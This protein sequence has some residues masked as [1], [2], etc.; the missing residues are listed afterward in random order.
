MYTV[1]GTGEHGVGGDGGAARR[2]QVG[3]A[4]DPSSYALTLGFAAL[5]VDYQGRVYIVDTESSRVRRLTPGERMES[6]AGMGTLGFAGDGA[7]ATEARFNRPQGIAIAKDGRVFI[8]DTNNNKIRV[9]EADG[10]IRT[11]AGTKTRGFLGDG[12]AALGARLASPTS[13]GFDGNGNLF[14]LDTG[15][16]RIRKIGADGIVSTVVGSGV[17]GPLVDGA[18]REVPLA[19]LRSLA[20]APDGTLVF[21]EVDDF[22]SPYARLRHVGAD[23]RVVSLNSGVL[24]YQSDVGP[25]AQAAFSNIHQISINSGGEILVADR[26]NHVIRQLTPQ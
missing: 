24:G 9:I 12:T 14:F 16:G 17:P 22:L 26:D 10:V 4:Y 11:F 2:A 15:N 7:S 18:A 8:A 1:A 5:A 23:Q 3:L 21:A 19:A 25:A 20:V 6:F 13:L